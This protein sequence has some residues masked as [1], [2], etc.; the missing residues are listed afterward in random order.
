[1]GEFLDASQEKK[2]LQDEDE[3]MKHVFCFPSEE[4]SDYRNLHQTV[5]GLINLPCRKDVNE[6]EGSKNTQKSSTYT[7][8]IHFRL[9]NYL[10]L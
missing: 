2:I 9:H 4:M 5:E 10:Y 6:Q 3:T 8:A 1:M 7:N